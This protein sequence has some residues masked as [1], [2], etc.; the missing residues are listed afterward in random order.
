MNVNK[1]IILF[2][3]L[4]LTSCSRQEQHHQYWTIDPEPF[5]IESI[6]NGYD[7]LQIR[8]WYMP[9]M[10]PVEIPVVTIK[11]TNGSWTG[12]VRKVLMKLVN[13]TS[14]TATKDDKIWIPFKIKSKSLIPK[15]NWES[16]LAK[17]EHLKLFTLPEMTSIPNLEDGFVDG[18]SYIVEIATLDKYRT[19]SYHVPEHFAKHWQARNMTEILDLIDRELGI[20]WNWERDQWRIYR[21]WEEFEQTADSVMLS[22]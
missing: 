1:Q 5:G 20:P 15:T 6:S 19:Y 22:N 18:E 9:P 21:T 8:I 13:D 17:M 14:A 7:S 4:G 2:L 16:I 11:R 12:T 10:G 3:V